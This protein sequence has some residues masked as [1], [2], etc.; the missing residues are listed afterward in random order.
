MEVGEEDQILVAKEKRTKIQ[1]LEMSRNYFSEPNCDVNMANCL[2]LLSQAL[3]A[4]R[5]SS[6]LGTF[7]RDPKGPNG[8]FHSPF[9][10]S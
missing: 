6:P 1:K 4:S 7:I 10:P 9:L 5:A 2:I 8:H 3:P